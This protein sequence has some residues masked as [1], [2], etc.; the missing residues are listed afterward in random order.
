MY[1]FIRAIRYV[2]DRKHRVYTELRLSTQTIQ[3]WFEFAELAFAGISIS[4]IEISKEIMP[5]SGFATQNVFQCHGCDDT[6]S[7]Q[8]FTL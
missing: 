7:I 3:I 1:T 4:I 2:E 5:M 6:L 8:I